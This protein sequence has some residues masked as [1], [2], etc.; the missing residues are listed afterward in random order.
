MDDEMDQEHPN[1]AMHPFSKSALN[2]R[3]LPR[4]NLGREG[5]S[6]VACL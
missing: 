4:N 5:T 3:P 2:L 6:Y 1:N